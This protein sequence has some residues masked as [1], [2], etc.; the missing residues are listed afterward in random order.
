M[1]S[2]NP[3]NAFEEAGTGGTTARGRRQWP[4]DARGIGI[5]QLIRL[6][7]F[8]ANYRLAE[9]RIKPLDRPLAMPDNMPGRDAL[10][11]PLFALLREDRANVRAGLYPQPADAIPTPTEWLRQA[12]A[13]FADLPKV[14]ARRRADNGRRDLRETPPQDGGDLGALPAYYTQN[15]HFQTDGYLSAD[16]AAL[17]DYQVDVLFSGATDAMRRLCLPPLV[18]AF[19][20]RQLRAPLLLDVACGT[21]RTM[22]FLKQRWPAARV[23]GLDLSAPYLTLGARSLA[24]LGRVHMVCANG[25]RIPLPDNSL[26]GV[27]C[28]FTFH[29]LPPKVRAVLSAEMFRVL[30][31]GGRCVLVDSLQTGDNPALDSLLE[32]FP[33]FYH[34]PYYDSYRTTDLG[35]VFEKAGFAVSGSHIGFLAKRFVLDKKR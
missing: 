33:R 8:T 18:E 2:V 25:E 34:E 5:G 11:E 26:D 3:A 14:D 28:I 29:E 32:Y 7:W 4:L 23:V 13:F 27:T 21:A 6:G 31:P 15:F 20:A 30:K 35:A 24:D 16:S 9:R 19:A 22:R 17:Y 12:R 10:I 1:T